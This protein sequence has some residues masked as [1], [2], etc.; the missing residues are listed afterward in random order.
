MFKWIL[1]EKGQNWDIWDIFRQLKERPTNA[2]YDEPQRKG[3]QRTYDSDGFQKGP[4]R[5][6]KGHR[7]KQ[8]WHHKTHLPKHRRRVK[9]KATPYYLPA[10]AVL[11]TADRSV[12]AMTRPT[13]PPKHG[14]RRVQVREDEAPYGKKEE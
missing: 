2:L 3:S 8:L 11:G 14:R 10:C 7:M 9:T 12:N 5:G 6:Q 4:Q 1:Q 13:C